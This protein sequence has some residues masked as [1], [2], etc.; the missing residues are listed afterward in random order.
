[1]RS[2]VL[3]LCAICSANV[4]AANPIAIDPNTKLQP[5][6]VKAFDSHGADARLRVIVSLEASQPSGLGKAQAIAEAQGRVIGAFKSENNGQ[7]LAVLARYQM[8][9]GF[10]AELTRGQVNALAKRGDVSFIEEMPV[11]E[12]LYPESHPLTDVDLAQGDYDGN[13]AVIAII[14]DGI[15]ATHPAFAGKLIDG[16]DFADF[17][18][19]PTIDCLDQ[20]HGQVRMR[21]QPVGGNRLAILGLLGQGSCTLRHI[22]LG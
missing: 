20:S 17:D 7:G 5:A 14:D 2:L 18:S 16:Y 10:S 8:L 3:A 15:D 6:L 4:F 11:H 12:K 1:M 21:H 22:D 19:D 13:G 9:F